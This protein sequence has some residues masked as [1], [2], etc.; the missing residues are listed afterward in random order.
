MV[1]TENYKMAGIKRFQKGWG[2]RDLKWLRFKYFK[3]VGTEKI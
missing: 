1:G 3:M 2:L